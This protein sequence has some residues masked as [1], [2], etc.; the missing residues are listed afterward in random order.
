MPRGSETTVRERPILFSGPMVKAI[1]E[2]RKTMTRRVVKPQPEDDIDGAR[3][4][5]CAPM[6]RGSYEFVGNPTLSPPCEISLRPFAFPG[7]RLWVR[8]TMFFHDTCGWRYS[9]DN[10][11][12]SLHKDSP[13]VSAMYSWAHHSDV[14]IG[15]CCRS[16]HM[17]RWASRLT[18]EV[19][20][21]RVERLQEISEQDAQAEGAEYDS[22]GGARGYRDCFEIGWNHINGKRAPWAS[23]PWVWALTFRRLA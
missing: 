12:V 6:R 20:R 22:L 1:L 23:N 11:A 2:G 18:L 4:R 9:A 10:A 15:G 3:L 8:E 21:V 7:D 14:G 16:I 17:P 5:A 13:H 19:V